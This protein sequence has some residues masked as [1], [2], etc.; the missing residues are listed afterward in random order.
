MFVSSLFVFIFYRCMTAIEMYQLSRNMYRA[1]AQF[2]FDYVIFDAIRI[3]LMYF[4][5]YIPSPVVSCVRSQEATCYVF[6][7]F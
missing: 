4:K 7:V 5:S 1:I 6:S 2:M 3:N